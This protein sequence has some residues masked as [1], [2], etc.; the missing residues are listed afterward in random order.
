VKPY[1][2]RGGNAYFLSNRGKALDV[3]LLDALEVDGD[4]VLLKFRHTER[5]VAFRAVATL[6]KLLDNCITVD[7]LENAPSFVVDTHEHERQIAF[8]SERLKKVVS[9]LAERMKKA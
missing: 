3:Y 2:A 4:E 6:R 7:D 5:S 8:I 9:F 1:E